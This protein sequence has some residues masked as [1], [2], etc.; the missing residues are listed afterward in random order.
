M[1]LHPR[2]IYGI[3]HFLR[4]PLS[5][6]IS[7]PQINESYKQVMNHPVA[8][9]IPK[10][11]FLPHSRLHLNLGQLDLESDER[12]D[13][14]VRHLQKINLENLYQ[15][16]LKRRQENNPGFDAQEH[17]SRGIVVDLHGLAIYSKNTKLE[18]C[19]TLWGSCN[20]SRECFVDFLLYHHTLILAR[21]AV[22]TEPRPTG[23]T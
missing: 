16:I 7:R 8:S 22:K 11:A 17:K 14:A 5:T 6:Y 15:G 2:E 1:G 3:T 4:L 18:D 13:A 12:Y 20:R 9:H 23:Q 19:M 21:W 10:Q